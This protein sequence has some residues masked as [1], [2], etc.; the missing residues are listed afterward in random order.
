MNSLSIKRSTGL[1]AVYRVN[2][3]LI[4]V[5]LTLLLSF[6]PRFVDAA[7]GG[8]CRQ[9]KPQRFLMRSSYVKHGMIDP[10]SHER[11]VNYRL[12]QYGSVPGIATGGVGMQSVNS[13]TRRTTFFG[14]PITLHEKVIPALG[15]VEQ[16]I[17]RHCTSP[18]QVYEPRSIGGLRTENTIR[19]GELSNH[20]F[21]IAIDI[22]P[23]RNPCCHCV[24][25]WQTHPKCAK[26]AKTPYDRA[27]LPRCWVQSFEAYGFYWLGLDS[28]E[29]TMHFEFL[30]DPQKS[31]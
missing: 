10:K 13:Q 6:S 14:L 15:C 19:Q 23:N 30:G 3:L 16:R 17:V 18:G 2:V 27:D 11:A 22:D 7:R 5:A 26:P 24:K 31:N 9:Q 1:V 28:L 20:L 12:G 29:D 8:R 25:K 4:G 21:G